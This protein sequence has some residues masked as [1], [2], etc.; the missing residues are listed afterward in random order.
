MRGDNQWDTDLLVLR[1]GIVDIH[2]LIMVLLVNVTMA[3]F[4]P[5]ASSRR[6]VMNAHSF[7]LHVFKEASPKWQEWQERKERKE[8]QEPYQRSQ[9]A[10]WKEWGEQIFRLAEVPP[11]HGPS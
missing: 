10:K 11:D 2:R 4:R 9:R 5:L 7:N 8:W 3:P 6:K 1:A